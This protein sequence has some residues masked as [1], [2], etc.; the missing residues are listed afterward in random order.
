MQNQS[1][2]VVGR[3]GPSG[4]VLIENYF[5]NGYQMVRGKRDNLA[6]FCSVIV[7]EMLPLCMI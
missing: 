6:L 2:I 7:V 4:N 3:L 5:S 1:D